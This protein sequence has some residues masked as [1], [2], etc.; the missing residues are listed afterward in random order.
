MKVWQQDWTERWALYSP[1]KIAVKE[2]ETGKSLS[3]AELNHAAV[4]TGSLLSEKYNIHAGDRVAIV[5]DFCIEYV[6]LFAAAQKFGFIL[7]PLNYRLAVPEVGHILDDCSPSLFITE[8][9]YSHYTAASDNLQNI[10]LE[11]IQS[12]IE[13][14]SLSGML[15]NYEADENDCV[16]IL[17]T[18]GTTGNPK[19]VKYT[20]KMLFWNSINTSMSLML[21]T[22]SRTVNVMPPF[23]T[24]GWNVLLTPFL[25]HGA[26]TCICKKFDAAKTLKLLV[27]EK[28]T[29]FMGVPTMLQMMAQ[30]SEFEQADFSRLYYIIVGGEAMPIPLIEQYHKKGVAIRQG[31]GMTEVGPN[32]TSLHHD[33]AIR[34]IG[35]I[36]RPN[37]YVQTRI[38]NERGQ[39]SH[40]NEPGELWLKGP[41]TT[42]GYWNNEKMTR[43]CFSEDEQWFKTGDLVRQDEEQYLYVV[44]RIKN[45]YISG[46][47]NVYPAEIEKV[48]IKLEGVKECTVIGVKDA[49]WGETGK[50]YIV[51]NKNVRDYTQ[52][53]LKEYCKSHLAKFKVPAYIEFLDELPKN[54]AGKIDKKLLRKMHE[55][56]ASG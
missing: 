25:H 9:K 11:Q 52:E 42:P 40:V 32:L 31:Y 18:S 16:F 8:S 23:H 34:K 47:E 39:D 22:E 15:Q 43:D 49:K 3:Y 38:I 28:V 44:D 13:N 37:F 21:N 45:M 7:V 50:A 36:G 20:H 27:E 17:Y 29:I 48:L 6:V 53:T 5:A 54:D 30:Q 14:D 24:G 4:R 41:M 55:M 51:L 46:G 2:S 26:Y 56:R 35:S 12:I 1:E 10:E 19:G 33:D